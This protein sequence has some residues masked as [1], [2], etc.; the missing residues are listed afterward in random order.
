M[1]LDEV[2]KILSEVRSIVEEERIDIS[3]RRAYV[4]KFP[5]SEKLRPLGVPSKS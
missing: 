2:E 1:K 3:L 5:G 4:P